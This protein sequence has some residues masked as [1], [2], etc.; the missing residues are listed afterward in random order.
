MSMEIE[1]KFLVRGD[2]WRTGAD[3]T[4][5][6]QG[7]LSLARERTVRIRAT[8]KQ[9][10]LTIKGVTRGIS[11]VE[12]EYAIPAADAQHLLD[13]LCLQPLIEKTRYAVRY[14]GHLWDIDE[15]HGA[16]QGLIVAE[17]E[18]GSETEV[19]E[20]PP[21]LGDEVSGDPRYFNSSLVRNPLGQC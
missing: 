8:E 13:E 9:A 12:F 17:I 15:F 4:R 6:R 18:L 14:G 11:R 3:G 16:N 10:W 1:R 2:A 5:I 21:W 19:F 7:Y 20:R